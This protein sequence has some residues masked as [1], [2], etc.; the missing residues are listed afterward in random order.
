MQAIILD[1]LKTK[2]RVILKDLLFVAEMKKKEG[3]DVSPGDEVMVQI[4]KSEPW[5]D[6][7][8]LDFMD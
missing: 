3:F 8:K 2:Y 1:T 4:K 6:V 7:L 5:D